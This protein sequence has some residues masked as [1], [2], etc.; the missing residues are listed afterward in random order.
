MN[1][2]IDRQKF[3]GYYFCISINHF[4]HFSGFSFSNVLCVMLC[5]VFML[6]LSRSW[7]NDQLGFLTAV[8]LFANWKGRQRR[9]DLGVLLQRKVNKKWA[10]NTNVH[11]NS[12]HRKNSVPQF[13][14]L[15][16]PML[17]GHFH[18]T[19]NYNTCLSGLWIVH[20]NILYI[21]HL[22]VKCLCF[23]GLNG[24]RQEVKIYQW[25]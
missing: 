23:H 5:N 11:T 3:F 10:G 20:C 17:P 6:I 16:N 14:M 22:I 24:S 25:M 8:V 13:R 9:R 1:Q 15:K 7:S 19:L 2:I 4:S 12:F 21:T 18:F